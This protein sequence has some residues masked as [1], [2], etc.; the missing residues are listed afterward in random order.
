MYPLWDCCFYYIS[1]VS[2][3][4]PIC[5]QITILKSCEYQ[6][7][8]A[9]QI[10]CLVFLAV[11]ND[12]LIKFRLDV[13]PQGEKGRENKSLLELSTSLRYSKTFLVLILSS[14]LRSHSIFKC[15]K[16]D[17]H[18]QILYETEQ[19]YISSKKRKETACVTN[20]IATHTCN[21]LCTYLQNILS[22]SELLL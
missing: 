22:V 8:L 19:A 9:L 11:P 2:F 20:H 10:Y 12:D 1:C 3:C 5:A 18:I 6:R 13:L 14:S 15:F 21:T 7:S 4:K 16:V 17:Y